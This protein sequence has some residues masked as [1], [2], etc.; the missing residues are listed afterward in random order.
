MDTAIAPI[1]Y[2]NQMEHYFEFIMKLITDFSFGPFIND[3][4]IIKSALLKCLPLMH[5]ELFGREYDN[6]SIY[7][8][9]KFTRELIG[10]DVS[11]LKKCDEKRVCFEFVFIMMFNFIHK[12]QLANE[13]YENVEAMLKKYPDF[14]NL[15][16]Y[17]TNKL[18][19]I[20]A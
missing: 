3:D 11:L 13:M 16:P 5:V 1:P 10:E 20:W 8:V 7:I 19:R 15:C 12:A 6:I 18:F 14:K 9:G 2:E 4:P 17:E